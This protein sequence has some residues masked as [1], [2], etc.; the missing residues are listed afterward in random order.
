MLQ[1]FTSC[2]QPFN[3]GTSHIK[4]LCLF[5]EKR[6]RILRKRQISANYVAP[7][8]KTDSWKARLRFLERVLSTSAMFNLWPL[9]I[10]LVILTL[11]PISLKHTLY[12]RGL[13]RVTEIFCKL[14]LRGVLNSQNLFS[15]A[16]FAGKLQPIM[17]SLA[18]GGSRC[19]QMGGGGGGREWRWLFSF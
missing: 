18:K 9:F 16:P 15:C 11:P 6:G 10:C 14:S 12:G 17:G 8:R 5:L 2:L 4:R 7:E 13:T 1:K 19:A 3:V